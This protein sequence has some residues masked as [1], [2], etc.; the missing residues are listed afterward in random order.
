LNRA[1]EPSGSAAVDE[2]QRERPTVSVVAGGTMKFTLVFEGEIPPRRLGSHVAVPNPP[3]RISDILG[4]DLGIGA[5]FISYL[6]AKT[7]SY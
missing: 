7:N 5:I 2:D 6:S 4:T 1:A 3:H